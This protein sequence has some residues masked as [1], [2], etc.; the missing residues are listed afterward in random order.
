MIEAGMVAAWDELCEC[1]EIVAEAG[2]RSDVFLQRVAA[3]FYSL[4]STKLVLDRA[5]RKQDEQGP[6]DPLCR[7]A[8]EY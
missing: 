6:S 1:A 7:A 8:E 4:A 3:L 5:L 2:G